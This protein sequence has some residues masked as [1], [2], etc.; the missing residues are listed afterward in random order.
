MVTGPAGTALRCHELYILNKVARSMRRHPLRFLEY[1]V[2]VPQIVQHNALIL[3][4]KHATGT[5]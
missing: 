2:S 5:R 3:A 1:E 4:D